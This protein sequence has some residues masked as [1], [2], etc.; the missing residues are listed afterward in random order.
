MIK[1]ALLGSMRW[2]GA[3]ASRF[4]GLQNV[5]KLL[6]WGPLNRPA[7]A[8]VVPACLGLLLTNEMT[9]WLEAF[10]PMFPHLSTQL[11]HSHT[12]RLA[13]RLQPA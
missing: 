2:C 9:R 1:T 5:L 6:I 11:Q 3:T 13:E 10:C 8:P 12:L 4:K 7:V